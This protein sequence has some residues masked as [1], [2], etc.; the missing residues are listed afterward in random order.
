V[1]HIYL[2]KKS[3]NTQKLNTKQTKQRQRGT[4]RKKS[5]IN[6]VPGENPD[7]I[8]KAILKKSQM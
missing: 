5:F 3:T 7:N 1:F 4:S 2:P 6:E 8:D